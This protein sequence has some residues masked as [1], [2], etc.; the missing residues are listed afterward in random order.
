MSMVTSHFYSDDVWGSR[1]FYTH[2]HNIWSTFFLIMSKHPG[3]SLLG[4]DVEASYLS[5]SELMK[6]LFRESQGTPPTIVAFFC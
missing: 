4:M 3:V 1:L 6:S 5:I 2:V